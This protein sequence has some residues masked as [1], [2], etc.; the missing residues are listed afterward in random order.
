MVFLEGF[1]IFSDPTIP[2]IQGFLEILRGLIA[3]QGAK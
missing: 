2:I 3:T 1:F